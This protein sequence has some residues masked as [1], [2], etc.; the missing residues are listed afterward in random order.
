MAA[1][2]ENPYPSSGDDAGRSGPRR[3]CDRPSRQF[4]RSRSP[5]ISVIRKPK[6]RDSSI[7]SSGRVPSKSE[8]SLV[9]RPRLSAPSN[10]RLNRVIHVPFRINPKYRG[11]RRNRNGATRIPLSRHDGLHDRRFLFNSHR[12]VRRLV[13]RTEV[14]EIRFSLDRRRGAG[15]KSI[16]ALPRCTS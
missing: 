15:Q 7:A 5:G 16:T 2:N 14:L 12:T 4:S 9:A 11:G 6:N 13:A 3:D 1:S 10:A 8:E